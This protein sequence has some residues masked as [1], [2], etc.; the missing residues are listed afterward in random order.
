[1]I[2]LNQKSHPAQ[3]GQA[4]LDTHEI[5]ARLAI[6]FAPRYQVLRLIGIGGMASVYLLR[7][8][9]HHGL[10]AVKVLHPAHAEQ[11]SLL[12]RFRR[13][14]LIGARLAGHPHIVPVLD[15]GEADGLHYL[16]MPYVRGEDLDHLLARIGPFSFE[17]AMLAATQLNQALLYAWNKGVLH[18]DLT[19]GNI[20]LNEF[21]QFLLVD[22]GLASAGL[23]RRDSI[24]PPIA[25]S[26]PGTPLYMSPEQI[27][28]DRI[29]I[30]S[31]L[32]ALGAI[33]YEMLTGHAAFFA[34]TLEEIEQKH[35][36]PTLSF[37]HPLLS[38]H[39]GIEPLLQSL[40]ARSPANRLAD[41]TELQQALQQLT[42]YRTRSSL[43]PEIE[44]E[45]E[46]TAAR[47]RLSFI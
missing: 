22:F 26:H 36:A 34:A 17:E 38:L 23:T 37:S 42:S 1:M 30:R 35:L 2:A 31:D 6:I 28:G 15:V 7:H 5:A 27:L 43:T 10:F 19:P 20:R 4:P 14:G 44:P 13:E 39:P 3:P 47:R 8:R 29:D 45:Q 24:L 33:L 40:L 46:T 16:V 12:A 21:G 9:I 18:C 25:A 32:Y 11:P 41:P